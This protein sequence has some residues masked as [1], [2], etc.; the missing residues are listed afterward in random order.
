MTAKN[1]KVVNL[2]GFWCGIFVL[3][4]NFR[5]AMIIIVFGNTR[6]DENTMKCTTIYGA[7]STNLTKLRYH[8]IVTTC[9]DE[10]QKART[11]YSLLVVEIQ[12][13]QETDSIFFY[14]LTNSRRKAIEL[15]RS[16]AEK[17]REME[18]LPAIIE[19]I[20]V[21]WEINP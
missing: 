5:Y 11:A 21:D 19:K 18:E 6:K 17:A 14:N 2:R 15:M 12:G 3:T 7:E 9:M 1:G 10:R 20:I 4:D 16:L 8:L 13:C